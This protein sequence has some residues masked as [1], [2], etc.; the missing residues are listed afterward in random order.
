[1]SID[2]MLSAFASYN[3]LKNEDREFITHLKEAYESKLYKHLS[4]PLIKII[5]KNYSDIFAHQ[6]SRTGF[7]LL[8][9]VLK[10]VRKVKQYSPGPSSLK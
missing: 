2:Y 9:F 1:M 4:F 3:N 8:N 6:K 5:L 10:Y 7:S